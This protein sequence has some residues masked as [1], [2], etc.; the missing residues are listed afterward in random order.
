[1]GSLTAKVSS[2]Q[3]Q[4]ARALPQIRRV[5]GIKCDAE[6]ASEDSQ[7]SAFVSLNLGFSGL[8][9]SR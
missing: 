6:L 9:A 7:T 1:M 8:H 4:F 5:R 2:S 3:P